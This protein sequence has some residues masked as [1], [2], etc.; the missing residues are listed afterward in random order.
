MNAKVKSNAVIAYLRVSTDRQELGPVAQRQAIEAYAARE[1]LRI[2]AWREDIGISGAAAIDRR[3]GLAAAID[4][5]RK[6][7]GSI[8]VAKRDRLARD[9][10]TALAVEKMLMRHGGQVVSADGVANGIEAHDVLLRSML[11][12]F[13]AFER[14]LIKAR[15][16][17]ARAVQTARKSYAGGKPSTGFRVVG[18]RLE[19]DDAEQS[20]LMRVHELKAQGASTRAI[21]RA[22]ASEGFANRAGKPYAQTSIVRMLQAA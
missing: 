20:T 5:A 21:V 10:F 9:Q 22:L 3:P 8:I 14:E 4:D 1:G 17:A 11:D 13:A 12:A 7:K 2:A 19:K 15:T 18:N 16:R 6:V